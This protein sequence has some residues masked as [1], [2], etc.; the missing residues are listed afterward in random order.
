MREL[1]SDQV[2]DLVPVPEPGV[3][4][5]DEG[6]EPVPEPIP[7]SVSDPVSEP[8]PVEPDEELPPYLEAELKSMKNAQLRGILN[9]KGFDRTSG[10]NKAALVAKILEIQES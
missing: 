5:H 7:E 10:M 6:P 1:T 2:I 9:S 4:I 8:V 3:V